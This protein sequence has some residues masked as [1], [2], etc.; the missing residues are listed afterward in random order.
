MAGFY[1]IPNDLCEYSRK[2]ATALEEWVNEWQKGFFSLHAKI[3][4]SSSSSVIQKRENG[5]DFNGLKD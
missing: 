2:A 5:R 4:S 3:F 1:F